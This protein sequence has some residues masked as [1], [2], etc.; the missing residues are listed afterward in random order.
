MTLQD[1]K[2]TGEK[3]PGRSFY[4]RN[5]FFAEMRIV[6]LQELTTLSFTAEG[7]EPDPVSASSIISRASFTQ[8]P[9]WVP[10]PVSKLK[11]RKLLTPLLTAFRIAES[12][13]AWQIQMYIV[14]A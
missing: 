6:Q 4:K 8:L 3:G 11:S 5:H 13:T 10:H 9:H 7:G 14:E 1:E 12:V 2:F